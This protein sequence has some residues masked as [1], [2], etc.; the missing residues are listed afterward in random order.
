MAYNKDIAGKIIAA[1][2]GVVIVR[3]LPALNSVELLRVKK[4]VAIG[5]AS[6]THF[7]MS[8]GLWYQVNLNALSGGKT[9][10]YVKA[11]YNGAPNVEISGAPAAS[12]A[13][14]QSA[15]ALADDIIKMDRLTFENLVKSYKHCQAIQKNGKKPPADILKKMAEVYNSLGDRQEKLKNMSGTSYRTA[16]LKDQQASAGMYSMLSNARSIRGVGWIQLVVI[17]VVFI[18]GAASAVAVYYSI[19]PDYTDAK[20]DLK[21]STDLEKALA[22]LSP[23][24]AQ[25]VR[26]NLE[27]QI[28]N[29]YNQGKT[30]NKFSDFFSFSGL[31]KTA[32]FGVLGFVGLKALMKKKGS[33]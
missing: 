32:L 5:R 13:A 23:E 14:E 25:N 8:D 26:D 24:S 2:D 28:D 30:D 20:A 11:F 6:G 31:G 17:L 18:I 21:I 7:T 3:T 27:Q 10:G 9:S 29:A 4:G 19:K 12:P 1:V 33:K 22:T 16:A 15:Q